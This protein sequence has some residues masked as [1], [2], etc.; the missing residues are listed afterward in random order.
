MEASRRQDI[1]KHLENAGFKVYFT[2]QHKGDCTFEYVVI[3]EDETLPYNA[4]SSTATYYDILCYVPVDRPT[5]MDRFF[6]EVKKAMRGLVP[7]IK[8]THS[9]TVEYIDD[10]IKARMKSARYLNYRKF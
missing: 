10:T 9:E 4:Y 5:C 1:F 6:E 2:G 3:K 8:P 7:M